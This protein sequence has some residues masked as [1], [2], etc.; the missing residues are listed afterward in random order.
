VH[1]S[2]NTLEME[3]RINKRILSLIEAIAKNG[4]LNSNDRQ[5]VRNAI[6][7]IKEFAR[8]APDVERYL[9]RCE[10][11]LDQ[12]DPHGIDMNA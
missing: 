4:Q 9:S 12:M 11:K 10:S 7:E 6:R 5:Q 1:S 8:M 2:N 3:Y